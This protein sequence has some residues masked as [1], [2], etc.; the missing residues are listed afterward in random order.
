[1]AWYQENKSNAAGQLKSFLDYLIT[2]YG[3]S[4]GYGWSIYD[5]AAGTN[6]GVYKCQPDDINSFILVIKDNQADYATVEYWDGW[7]TGTHSGVGNSLTYGRSPSYLFRIR[8]TT[9]LYGAAIS[10]NRIALVILGGAWGYYLGYPARWDE[11]KNTPIYIGH[12]ANTGSYY[13]DNPLGGYFSAG[14]TGPAINWRAFYNSVGQLN[15][16]LYAWQSSIGTLTYMPARYIKTT[17]GKYLVMED[18]ITEVNSPNLSLGKLEGVMVLGTSANGLS[19]GDTIVVGSEVWLA[20]IN[21][22]N[23]LSCLIR[24][25]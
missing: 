24:E 3:M 10:K 18:P 16:E 6:I 17:A 15:K 9:G 22:T 23:N 21:S 11:T 14:T 20:I 13:S 8:K 5:S 4:G 19:N 25:S 7:D 2:N 12:D 1:M